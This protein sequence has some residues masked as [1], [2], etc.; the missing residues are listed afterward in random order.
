MDLNSYS[1]PQQGWYLT[2]IF[3]QIHTKGKIELGSFIQIPIYD[4]D[5]KNIA[6][7][8]CTVSESNWLIEAK[9]CI[10]A[11]VNQPSLV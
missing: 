2:W 6:L 1:N 5:K 7:C 10:Y 8:Q 11:S 3:I 4:G 9:W